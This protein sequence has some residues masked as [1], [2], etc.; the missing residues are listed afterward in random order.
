V[1][2]PLGPIGTQFGHVLSRRADALPPGTGKPRQANIV[3]GSQEEPSEAISV[4]RT[5]VAVT[6]YGLSAS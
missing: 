6:E 1:C 3:D 2:F 4:G 5:V